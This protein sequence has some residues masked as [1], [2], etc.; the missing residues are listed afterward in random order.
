MDQLF[1]FEGDGKIRVFNGNY[2]DYRDWVDD[3]EA[4]AASKTTKALVS[5]S[6]APATV[7]KKK[8]S[9]K[10]KQEFEKLQAEIESLEKKKTAITEEFAKANADHQQLQQLSREIKS[11]S[12]AIDEKTLRWL[13]L[14]ELM[15]Q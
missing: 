6:P 10:E 7:E 8:F 12:D 11:V 3:E 4:R 5:E 1:V 14:S 2:T 9:F 15:D 13:E